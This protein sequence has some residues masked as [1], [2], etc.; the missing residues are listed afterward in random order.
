MQ[1]YQVVYG[2][3]EDLVKLTASLLRILPDKAR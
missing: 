3:F 2:G 1:S